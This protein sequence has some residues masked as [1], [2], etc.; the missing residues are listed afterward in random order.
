MPGNDWEKFANSRILLGYMY[1]HPGKKLLFMGGEFGQ[2]AEWSHEHELQWDL[3]NDAPHNQVQSWVKDLNALYKNEPAL[4]E[5]DFELQGFEWLDMGHDQ[6]SVF[7]FLRKGYHSEDHILVICNFSNMTQRDYTVGSPT[8]GVWKEILNSDDVQYGGQGMRA[9][10]KK[11]V[12]ARKWKTEKKNNSAPA[13][14]VLKD[15]H[16]TLTLPPLSII[17]LQQRHA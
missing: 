2:R 13:P 10:G 11:A 7:S 14:C 5:Q 15:Y 17:F 1:G 4:Y 16:L 12:V 9:E 8:D 6:K 3:L